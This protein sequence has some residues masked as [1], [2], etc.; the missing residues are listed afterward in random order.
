MVPT[1]ADSSSWNEKL[2]TPL[3]LFWFVLNFINVK[4]FEITMSLNKVGIQLPEKP[5]LTYMDK[6]P[7]YASNLKPPKMAK[8]LTLMRGPELIH[9]EFIHKQYGIVVSIKIFK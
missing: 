4:I 5:K 1:N 9:N 3:R 7:T 2:Y 8:R 6:V